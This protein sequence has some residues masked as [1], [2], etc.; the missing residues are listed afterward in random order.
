[1]VLAPTH[2]YIGSVYLAR[3][4]N[5]NYSDEPM[6]EVN[7][8]SDGYPRYTV[9][10]ITNA[11]KRYMNDDSTPTFASTGTLPTIARIEHCGGRVIFATPAGSGSDVITCATGHYLTVTE[12]MGVLNWNLSQSWKE[13][14]YMHLGDSCQS[15]ALIHKQWEATSDAHWMNTQA[16][17][18]TTGG[19]ANSH[20]TLT[21]VPGGEDGNNY[22]LTLVD[23]GTTGSLSVSILGKAITATLA[24]ATGAITTTA[25]QLAA[26]INCPAVLAAGIVA[27][28]ADGETGAGIVAEL[29]ET[30]LA[31]GLD[32]EDYSSETSK[33]VVVLYTNESGDKRYE[34][35][36]IIQKFTPN[37]DAGA[38]IKTNLTFKNH[39][40]AP[41]YYRKG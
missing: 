22:S 20:I 12:F 8:L 18:T 33:V 35:F 10:E 36:G 26:A 30:N 27:T 14:A 5:N 16:A 32:A 17:L 41:L 7:L 2:G 29:S 1:M 3:G 9:Y 15:S 13:E 23:P 6:S 28:V 21:H 39:G 4:S 19:N 38:L 31:G 40:P 37:I 24:Y 34:G 25:I 11:A